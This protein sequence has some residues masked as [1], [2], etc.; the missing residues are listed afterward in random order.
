MHFPI[1]APKPRSG[2]SPVLAGR[3]LVATQSTAT[4]R[5]AAARRLRR[6]ESVAAPTPVPQL[7]A[8][9]DLGGTTAGSGRRR[10]ANRHLAHCGAHLAG[11]E[12]P[13]PRRGSSANCH[14]R[15]PAG[16][17]TLKTQIRRS[18]Q[19]SSAP[20][21]PRDRPRSS[22]LC[23]QD[24]ST[25]RSRADE[26]LQI[27]RFLRWRRIPGTPPPSAGRSSETTSVHI[28]T[29][30]SDLFSDR[31]WHLRSGYPSACPGAMAGSCY[32]SV[33][34]RSSPPAR[35]RGRLLTP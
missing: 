20:Q 29:R 6:S 14:T 2:P 23:W 31:N 5:L 4:A 10:P 8:R 17:L 24:V 34:P 28:H 7:S 9:R 1:D 15:Q 3:C 33:P 30:V 16:R 26:S 35:R 32:R 27:P 22:G 25:A 11:P 21:R 19:P 12:L 18:R 13:L